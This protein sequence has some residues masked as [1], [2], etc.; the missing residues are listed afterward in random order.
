[1]S[2]KPI[3]LQR[4]VEILLRALYSTA[5]AYAA[6]YLGAVYFYD[7][8]LTSNVFERY[9]LIFGVANMLFVIFL[10]FFAILDEVR[11]KRRPLII[12]V[13]NLRKDDASSEFSNTV[14]NVLNSALAKYNLKRCIRVSHY[15]SAHSIIERDRDSILEVLNRFKTDVSVLGFADSKEHLFRLSVLSV[16]QIQRFGFGW[17]FQDK[18]CWT[19]LLLDKCGLCLLAVAVIQTPRLYYCRFAGEVI[20]TLCN[21]FRGVAAR[22]PDELESQEEAELAEAFGRSLLALR[23]AKKDKSPEAAIGIEMQYLTQA[24]RF[25]RFRDVNRWANIQMISAGALERRSKNSE[26]SAEQNEAIRIYYD[27][28]AQFHPNKEKSGWLAIQAALAQ[29]LV[30]HGTRTG[31]K[32]SFGQALTACDGALDNLPVNVMPPFEKRLRE[33]RRIAQSNLT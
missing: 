22:L 10:G 7:Y 8:S 26:T 19:N 33:L 23:R 4:I 27:L 32:I 29:A 20:E 24:A 17:P 6:I 2:R 28:I 31:D 15:A 13:P 18:R 5:I 11:F 30:A 12:L 1:M 16:D 21:G 14:V 25:W 9:S 3:H